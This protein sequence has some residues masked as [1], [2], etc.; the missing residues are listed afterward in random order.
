[1]VLAGSYPGGVEGTGIA[2]LV[3]EADEELAARLTAEVAASVA[4]V[5]AIPAP[6][7]QHLTDDASDDD[8]GRV[9]VLSAIEALED[10]TDTIVDAAEALDITINVT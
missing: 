1:M 5:A 2:D 10:Q 6:F 3:A 4:A 8:P 7:D 9:A